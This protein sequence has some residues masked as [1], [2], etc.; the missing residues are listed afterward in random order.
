V[1]EGLTAALSEPIANRWRNTALGTAVMLW[2]AFALLYAD[3]HWED[4]RCAGPTS[5]PCRLYRAEPVGPVL[6]LLAA[7]CLVA[8]SAFLAAALAPR[9]LTLLTTDTWLGAP[10]ALVRL[11]LLLVWWQGRRRD[12]L[13][14]RFK[15]LE[16]VSP[17]TGKVTE[18]A[19]GRQRVLENSSESGWMKEGQGQLRLSA[20]GNAFAAVAVRLES[21]TGLNV[22]VIWQPLLATLPKEA[23]DPLSARTVVILSRCQQLLLLLAAMPLALLLPWRFAWIWLVVCAIGALGFSHALTAEARLFATQVFTTVILHRPKLYRA[24]GLEPPR[25]PSGEIH[26]GQRLTAL[27]AALSALDAPPSGITYQW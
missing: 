25:T 12:G 7:V 18:L 6:L 16:K 14:R 20:A 26:D 27:V 5:L 3:S 15:E 4:S 1:I 10:S 11:G 22:G 9:L 8:L 2:V 17:A 24:V 23:L 19:R 13:S 21:T